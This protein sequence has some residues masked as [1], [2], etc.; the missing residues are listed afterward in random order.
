MSLHP[1]RRTRH[2]GYRC[3]FLARA[4]PK[5]VAEHLHC[6]CEKK[7][8]VLRPTVKKKKKK[9]MEKRIIKRMSFYLS[10]DRSRLQH[11]GLIVVQS[12]DRK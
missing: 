1:L 7:V 5:Y 2:K 11:R 3:L 4:A 12:D 9:K 10:I 6:R 8:I